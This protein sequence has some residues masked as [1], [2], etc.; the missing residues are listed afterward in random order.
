MPAHGLVSRGMGESDNE[1]RA[2]VRGGKGEWEKKRGGALGALGARGG[3]RGGP[4]GELFLFH[5]I[6]AG[7]SR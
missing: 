7:G 1:E 6:L 4:G 3:E 2:R 5:S